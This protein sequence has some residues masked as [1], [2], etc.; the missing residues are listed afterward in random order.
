MLRLLLLALCATQHAALLHAPRASLAPR[1]STTAL[2]ADVAENA[3][4][5]DYN[6]LRRALVDHYDRFH[7]RSN[8]SWFDQ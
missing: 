1:T 4:P 3:P 2:S 5:G 6:S 7:D 8:C